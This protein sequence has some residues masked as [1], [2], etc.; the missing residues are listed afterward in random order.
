MRKWKCKV[1]SNHNVATFIK[2]L[3]LELPEGEEVPFRAG[4]LHPDRVPAPRGRYKDFDVEE[5]YRGPTGTSSTS[6]ATSPR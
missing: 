5:E 4:R 3:I 6:G 1:R 2:E